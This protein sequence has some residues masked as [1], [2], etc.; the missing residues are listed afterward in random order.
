MHARMAFLLVCSFV[1]AGCVTSSTDELLSPAPQQPTGIVQ[2]S[3]QFPVIG[4]APVAQTRQM[5]DQE[6]LEMQN[7]LEQ[8]SQRGRQQAATNSENQYNREISE[9]LRLAKERE[10]AMRRKIEGE[11]STQ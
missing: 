6:R 8:D 10:E 11:S 3:G 5:T 1:L 2:Q 7:A 9:L 4:Q